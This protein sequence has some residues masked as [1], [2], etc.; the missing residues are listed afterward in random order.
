MNKKN[1]YPKI[2][3]ISLGRINLSDTYNNGL[4]LRNLF[5]NDWPRE[6][7][8]Q[9]YSSGDS[10][11][12]GFFGRYYCLGPKDR[13]LGSLFYRFKRNAG[14][15]V[16]NN[17]NLF[18]VN[19]GYRVK[20]LDWFKNKINSLVVDTG[21][22]EIIFRPK[23]SSEMISWVDDFKPDIILAQGYNITFTLIPLMLK[24]QTGVKL[25]ILSTDDWPKYQYAGMHGECTCFK[26]VVR[27]VINNL[28]KLIYSKA[29]FTFAFGMPM[30][31]EYSK[32]Y[33]K[34][35]NVLNH[36]DDNKR[37]SNSLPFRIHD[38]DTLSIVAIGTFNK[39][40]YPLIL[41]LNEACSRLNDKGIK[42]RG[43]IFSS[44]ID[45]IGQSELKNSRFIDI[46]PDPGNEAL[47]SRLK[48]GDILLLAEGFD[49]KF[50]KAIEL[51]VSSKAHLFMFSQ[52]PIIVYSDERAGIAKYTKSHG[53]AFLV[54]V[55]SSF[56]LAA[57]IENI[58]N[59]PD[60]ALRVLDLANQIVAY[61]H[62]HSSNRRLFLKT[63]QPI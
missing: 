21:I 37:F 27:P 49:D 52:R 51:S 63:I 4:F 22:Y 26:W 41:D 60:E 18:G 61:N 3:V 44:S 42:V 43:V 34:K 13:F 55:R 28:A 38:S 19:S 59:N 16:N 25:A 5:G 20:I 31:E 33:S 9:I 17:K 36:S 56:A 45:P 14:E 58:I 47:P 40:R 2:L 1:I 62:S 8:A 7:L 53:W 11:D 35:F 6:N 48:G 39:Y 15:V 29:D 12:Q 30:A 50:V 57:A 24:K 10:G 46:F 32:R 54:S 23:L